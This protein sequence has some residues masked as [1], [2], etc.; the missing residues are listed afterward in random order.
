[1]NTVKNL[2]Q[3]SSWLDDLCQRY[4]MLTTSRHSLLKAM[5]LLRATFLN[6]G[7]LLVCG[8]GGSAADAEHL[9]GELM[10]GFLK[11]RPLVPDLRNKLLGIGAESNWVDLL[12][13]ALPVIPLS[14]NGALVTAISNDL[15]EELI[16]AQQV[17][18]LGR[19]GDCLLAISTSGS[20]L[21]VVRAVLVAKALNLTTIGLTGGTGG[22]LVA[23]CDATVVVPATLTYQIQEFH[24]PIYHTFCAVLEECFFD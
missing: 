1:M 19:S 22:E 11:K 9:S 8:N 4:P 12:Q 21:N 14:V 17:L 3:A 16:F 15:G 18:G 5:E 23:L 6:G 24:L 7:K 2:F 20:S 13:E 10:K